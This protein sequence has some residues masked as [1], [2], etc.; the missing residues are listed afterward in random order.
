VLHIGDGMFHE[1][2]PPRIAE[3]DQNLVEHGD[4]QREETD[5]EDISSAR[6]CLFLVSLR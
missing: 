2:G 4:E 3:G 1:L 5:D 6:T